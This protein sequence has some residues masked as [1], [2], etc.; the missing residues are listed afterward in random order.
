MKDC[1]TVLVMNGASASERAPSFISVVKQEPDG[2]YVKHVEKRL[3]ERG[4]PERFPGY[5]QE[6][7]R[8]G[9]LD[10]EAIDLIAIL[11]GPGSFTGLRASIAF[12]LGMQ[13]G[14]GCPVVALRRG[15]ALFP[16]LQKRFPEKLIWHVTTAR[17]NRVFIETNQDAEVKA[18]DVLDIPWP[19]TEF[20]LAG[21]AVADVLPVMPAGLC[22]I[23][24]F[25]DEVD[26]VMIA[27]TAVQYWKEGKKT[28]PL[29]PL[30]IDPPKAALPAGGLRILSR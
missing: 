30:Y 8:Q 11:I 24:A 1:K 22:W 9:K 21:E 14:L 13:M 19:L 10:P 3:V 2:T 17:R 18:Y 6:F 7:V 26:A 15:E 16:V 20:V 27:E 25:L 12:V 23:R 28:N 29:S 5:L 4:G